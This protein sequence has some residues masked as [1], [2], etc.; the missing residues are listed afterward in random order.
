MA[1]RRLTDGELRHRPDGRRLAFRTRQRRSNQAT[2][3]GAFLRIVL[4]L[5]RVFIGL[6]GRRGS[7]GI[8]SHRVGNRL[9][10]DVGI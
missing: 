9:F 5:L 10:L 2:M 6:I 8:R 7:V 4:R 1:S 3:G